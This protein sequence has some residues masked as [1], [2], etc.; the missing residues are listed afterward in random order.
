MGPD[1][2]IRRRSRH[3]GEWLVWLLSEII[4]KAGDARP[5]FIQTGHDDL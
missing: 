4:V 2:G 3:G 1:S 5:G